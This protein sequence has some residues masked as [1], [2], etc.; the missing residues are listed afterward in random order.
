[1]FQTVSEGYV[2]DPFFSRKA[3]ADRITD[4]HVLLHPQVHDMFSKTLER[5]LLDPSDL[6]VV[7]MK[8][9]KLVNRTQ[10]ESWKLLNLVVA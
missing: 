10:C 1:M 8:S 6:V 9:F 7:N 3:V 5:V 4:L 2:C